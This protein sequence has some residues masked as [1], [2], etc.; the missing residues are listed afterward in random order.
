MFTLSFEEYLDFQQSCF[1][2][3][4]Q[5]PGQDFTNYLRKGGFPVVHALPYEEEGAYKVVRDIYASVLLRDT[6]QRHQIRD[7]ELLERVIRFTFDNIGN[8]FSG[9]SIADYFKSQFRKVDVNTI[10]NY[11][12]ALEEAF[13][14][15]RVSRYDLKGK[16]ILKTQEKFYVSDLSLIHAILGFRDRLISGLLENLVFLEL[17]RRGYAVYVGKLGDREID[18]VA[19]RSGA[20]VYIQVAYKLESNQTVDR[21]FGPLLAISDQYPKYVVT[22]DD[23]WR[24]DVLGVK[25]LHIRD[26][27]RTSYPYG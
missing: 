11:L 1:P 20:K 6:I 14:L 15:R 22:M 9:K 18:F 7:V 10:Y 5:D 17:K 2:D 23:F 13:V 12:N 21:E 3:R 8:T 16:E 24:E 19:E 26:F 4:Q 25:H 27:L